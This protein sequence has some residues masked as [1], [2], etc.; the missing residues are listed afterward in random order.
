MTTYKVVFGGF[1]RRYSA[2]AVKKLFT[3]LGY[4]PSIIRRNKLLYILIKEFDSEKEAEAFKLEIKSKGYL[5]T[6]IINGEAKVA[7][8]V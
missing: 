7:V 1:S 4:S 5:C 3:D 6:Q 2:L 8:K